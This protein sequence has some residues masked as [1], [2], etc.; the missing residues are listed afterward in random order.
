MEEKP[1]KPVHLHELET[2]FRDGRFSTNVVHG[3]IDHTP[4]FKLL[5][6][7]NYTLAG[8]RLKF[9]LSPAE[10]AKIET[11]RM[12]SIETYWCI[13]QFFC[14][15]FSSLFI[16]QEGEEQLIPNKRILTSH[17]YVPS[18][19]VKENKKRILKERAKRKQEAERKK[20]L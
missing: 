8:I 11:G 2:P 4:L 19:E 6:R 16:V 10:I 5:R 12:A 7:N 9:A 14:K 15:D 17:S 18:E 20:K 3:N 1:K 13:S